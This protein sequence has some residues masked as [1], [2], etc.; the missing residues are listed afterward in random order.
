MQ[1]VIQTCYTAGKL[2]KVT[3]LRQHWILFWYL[4]NALTLECK[5]CRILVI[6]VISRL[7]TV[8]QE[9][10]WQ[11]LLKLDQHFKGSVG[12]PNSTWWVNA[13]NFKDPTE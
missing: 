13:G 5:V 6:L 12:G 7:T 10:T 1:T 2:G 11:S 4:P 8:V 3:T 9:A